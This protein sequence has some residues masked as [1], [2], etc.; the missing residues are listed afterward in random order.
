M[1]EG[2]S[3]DTYS[4]NMACTWEDC[5]KVY[6]HSQL[7]QSIQ[8]RML[9]CQ[10]ISMFHQSTNKLQYYI[11]SISYNRKHTAQNNTPMRKKKSMVKKEEN[12]IIS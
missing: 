10:I 6:I 3:E 1:Y 12:K 9:K 5:P 8:E 7:Q 4:Y 11:H 2:G